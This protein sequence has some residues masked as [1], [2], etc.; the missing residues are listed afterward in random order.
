MADHHA[1]SMTHAGVSACDSR[2][3][4]TQCEA[5]AQRAHGVQVTIKRQ[6]VRARALLWARAVAAPPSPFQ[7]LPPD[8][9]DHPSSA[10]LLPGSTTH[11]THADH[12]ASAA[13]HH[14]HK[15]SALPWGGSAAERQPVAWLGC[16]R[17]TLLFALIDCSNRGHCA[18]APNPIASNRGHCARATNPICLLATNRGAWGLSSMLEVVLA[19]PSRRLPFFLTWL[20]GGHK[21]NKLLQWLLQP[22]CAREHNTARITTAFGRG[23]SN[24]APQQLAALWGVTISI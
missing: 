18:H 17:C 1:P 8:L 11:N 16:L 5:G 10:R 6:H 2:H 23:R 4:R 3:Q 15:S 7:Q 19:A 13:G 20:C 12:S 14:P 9:R 24:A 21:I 22:T